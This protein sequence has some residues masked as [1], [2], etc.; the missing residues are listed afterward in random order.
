MP[1]IQ[2]TEF[3]FSPDTLHSSLDPLAGGTAYDNPIWTPD[4][5][6][7]HLNRTET[8]WA[9]GANGTPGSDGNLTTINFGFHASQDD[10]F[11]NGYVYAFN[12]GLLAWRSS[13]TSRRLRPR[14]RPRRAKRSA[15]GTTSSR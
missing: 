3:D 8:G 7:A 2:T 6:A 1:S 10:L 5:I 12:G 11:N 9:V 13:S 14:S 15:I 4:Q